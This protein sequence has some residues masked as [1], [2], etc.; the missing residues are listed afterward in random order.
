M[1]FPDKQK[2]SYALL[3]MAFLGIGEMIGGILPGLII[4]KIGSKRTS[5]VQVVL[6]ILM[7]SITIFNLNLLEY[8]YWTYLMCFLWGFVDAL[9]NIHSFQILGFEFA[10]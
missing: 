7:I 10:S 9:N 3:G 2:E 4:D 8:T 5:I 1:L 6:V